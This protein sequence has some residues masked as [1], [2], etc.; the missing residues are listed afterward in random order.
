MDSRMAS[1]RSEGIPVHDPCKGINKNKEKYLRKNK[2]K[3]FI[4]DNASPVSSP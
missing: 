4:N 1:I 3:E 2:Y